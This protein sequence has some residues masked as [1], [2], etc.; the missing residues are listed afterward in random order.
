MTHPSSNR[1]L[2]IA[3]V[4][5]S[6]AMIA[7]EATIVSTA[8]PQIAAQLGQLNLYSWVFSS[9]LLAQTAMTVVFG[10]LSDIYGRKPIILLGTAIFLIASVLAGFAWSMPSM[11]AF[12][13]LQGI[14]AGAIQPVIMTVVGDLYPGAER[15]KV[16]GYLASVWALSAVVGP[17][18]GSVIVHSLPWAWV[19]W[20]NVPIGIASALGFIV[21]LHEEKQ[22]RT[23]S[24]DF[25]GA[26]LFAVAISAL[27][28][29]LTETEGATA[30][31]FV[32]LA[33]F[34]VSFLLFIWQE[35]RAEAP[36]I[37]LELWLKRPIA[38]ANTAVFL[39]SMAIMGLTTFLPMYVQ[40]V[41]DRSPLVAGFA[42]TMLLVG[43]PSGGTFASRMF[44]RFGLRPLMIAGSVF[45]P[46]GTLFLVLLTPGS[47]PVQAGAGSLLM[48]F[49]MGLLN[50]S[51]L[52]IIQDNVGWSERGSATASNVFSRNLGSTLGA[53]L[54]GAVLTYG[55][56][57][58]VAGPI[59][60]D[61]V[62]DLLQGAGGGL[63]ADSPVRLALQH[64]L[65]MT[66][67]AMFLITALIV[68]ACLGVPGVTR[69]AEAAQE[70]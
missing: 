35:R 31:M 60:S 65:H 30:Y 52:V 3:A 43:W 61:Q 18:L 41:L 12:R 32:S 46:V 49:G 4:M 39:A 29:A 9:F 27:M 47:S 11:I 26:G 14:G 19:F 21:Y 48:G 37:S 64:A 25:L 15:G 68:V 67:I 57:N 50:I 24:I 22:T 55:L 54:L 34:L 45:V 66:F 70:S 2:V 58:S 28:I 6:M 59:T 51:G 36:M 69:R 1:A 62:R 40:T 20:I 38:F 13:L 16:Q 5:A 44:P 8:M 33:V 53:A 63:A 17:L 56:A 10:K 7:I 23:V 42:L